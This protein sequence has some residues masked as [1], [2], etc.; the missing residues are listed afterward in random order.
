MND[1]F[2]PTCDPSLRSLSTYGGVLSVGD[3]LDGAERS[4]HRRPC[5]FLG[6]IPRWSSC[7]EAPKSSLVELLVDFAAAA[8]AR[9]DAPLLHSKAAREPT[10]RP[11]RPRLQSIARPHGE[12]GHV[13]GREWPAEH[14]RR[15]DEVDLPGPEQLVAAERRHVR[16]EVERVGTA[17]EEPARIIAGEHVGDGD[18]GGWKLPQRAGGWLSDDQMPR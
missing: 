2:P 15:E 14:R 4:S 10:T 8:P 16:V 5:H 12:R 11:R 1:F 13:G 3:L 18:A 17:H 6:I 9:R 7:L